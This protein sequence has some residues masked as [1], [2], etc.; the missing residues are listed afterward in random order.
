MSQLVVRGALSVL[1]VLMLAGLSAQH[2]GA[3]GG[4]KKVY[5][6]PQE[7]FEAAKKAAQ[8]NDIKGIA[9]TFTVEGRDQMAGGILFFSLMMR[10]FGGKFGKDEDKDALKKLD[11]VLARHGITKE[12]IESLPKP[13]LT[14]GKKPDAEANK[15]ALLKLISPVKDKS[16]LIADL[17]AVLPKKGD[18]GDGIESLKTATLKD[19]TITGDTAKGTLVK[20][21]DGA[22]ETEPLEFKREDGSWRI[23]PPAPKKGAFGK[24]PPG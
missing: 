14:T 3:G 13:E 5:K 9:D 17:A 4:A 12:F 6:T 23:V 21:K 11:E 18:K 1:T 7:A 20:M 2:V 19:V 8:Q 22:E 10:E 24:G 16:A 15:K